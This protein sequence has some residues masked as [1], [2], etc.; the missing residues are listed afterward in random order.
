MKNNMIN[1]AQKYIGHNYKHFCSAFWGGCFAWCA[2][3]ISVIGK[4][5]GNGDIIPWSTSC[6]DQIAKFKN[7]GVWHTDK[8]VEPGDILYYDWDKLGDSR[9]ADHVGVVESVNGNDIVVIEGNFGNYDSD[10]TV[11]T[12]RYITKSYP[13]IFGYARPKYIE[14]KAEKEDKEQETEKKYKMVS[15]EL[16]QISK[17]STGKSV[18]VMQ[19]LLE[20]FG[21][22]VGECGIDGEFGDDTKDAVINFQK[23]KKISVDGI[24]GVQTWSALLK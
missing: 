20:Q 9:P 22:S 10:Q 18:K 5:S 19:T 24:C 4:E 16:R 17:G 23:D 3:F 13:Y 7:D 1:T 6:N 8:N 2:A 15:V 21:Y 12:R 14:N 11:V